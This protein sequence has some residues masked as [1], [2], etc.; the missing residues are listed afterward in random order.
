MPHAGHRTIDFFAEAA[1]PRAADFF[2]DTLDLDLTQL[3]HTS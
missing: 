3:G 1:L 2:A